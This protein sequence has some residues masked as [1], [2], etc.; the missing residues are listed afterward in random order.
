MLKHV[1]TIKRARQNERKRAS[2][3]I[4]RSKMKSAIKN[5]RQAAD[6][7][8]AAQEFQK[9]A[10]ILDRMAVKGIIHKNKASNLKSKLHGYVQSLK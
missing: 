5:V 8:T 10:A 1:S 6:K 3:R 2:N 4:N 7:E 9:T